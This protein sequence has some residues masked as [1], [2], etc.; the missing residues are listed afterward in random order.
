MLAKHRGREGEQGGG[1][2]GGVEGGVEGD[3][4]TVGGGGEGGVM[5]TAAPKA[6]QKMS[7]EDF[8]SLFKK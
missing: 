5:E 1:K 6:T 8:R 2:E 4:E 7:N 3:E